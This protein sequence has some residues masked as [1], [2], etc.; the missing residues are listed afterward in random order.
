MVERGVI[1]KLNESAHSAQGSDSSVLNIAATTG[2][3]GLGLATVFFV[4]VALALRRRVQESGDWVAHGL[5]W[6]TVAWAAASVVNN[7]IFY[8]LI[9]APW[10]LLVGAILAVPDVS[11]VRKRKGA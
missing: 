11:N 10:A 5:L 2:V 8:T 7:V 3:I 9:L 4:K 1:T 6:F